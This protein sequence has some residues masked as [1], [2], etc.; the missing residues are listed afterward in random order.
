MNIIFLIN[1]GWLL[2]IDVCLNKLNEKSQTLES[3]RPVY[4][5][6]LQASYIVAIYY[7]PLACMI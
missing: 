6:G 7:I 1:G 3:A 5:L 2:F 4:K